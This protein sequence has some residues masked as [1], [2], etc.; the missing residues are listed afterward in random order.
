MVFLVIRYYGKAVDLIEQHMTIERKACATSWLPISLPLQVSY[1]CLGWGEDNIFSSCLLKFFILMCIA[2]L[3]S[4]G[5]AS[6]VTI[7]QIFARH[8]IVAQFTGK[9][10]WNLVQGDILL[11]YS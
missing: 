11:L 1:H 10:T 6:N 4:A 5:G 2:C 7:T 9:V 8:V 3:K